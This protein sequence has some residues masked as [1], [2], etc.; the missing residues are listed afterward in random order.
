[1]NAMNRTMIL[2]L[3]GGFL[4]GAVYG[5]VTFDDEPAPILDRHWI[6]LVSGFLWAI[7]GMLVVIVVVGLITAMWSSDQK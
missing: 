7:P 6:M 4:A 2:G 5:F 1:M 3:I